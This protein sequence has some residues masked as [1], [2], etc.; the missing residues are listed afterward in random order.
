MLYEDT[1]QT[2]ITRCLIKQAEH[3]YRC[4]A[5][6]EGVYYNVTASARSLM[7]CTY[8]NLREVTWNVLEGQNSSVAFRPAKCTRSTPRRSSN[9]SS[10]QIPYV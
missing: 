10:A 4:P 8:M 2:R 7:L 1:M 3:R 5:Q 9:S 6:N